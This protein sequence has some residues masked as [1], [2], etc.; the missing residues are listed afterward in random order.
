[1]LARSRFMLVLVVGAL[2]AVLSFSL[3]YLH[4]IPTNP[5]AEQKLLGKSRKRVN[6]VL[7]TDPPAPDPIRDT[8]R[9]C[10][11]PNLTEHGWEGHSPAD[12]RLLS[13]HVMIR[14]GDR[15]PLYSI[16]K[17]KKPAIDCVL[18]DKRKPSHPLLASFI[19]HMALGGRGHWDHLK[20]GDHLRQAYIK[21]HSLLTADWS[22]R[23]L[24]VET[25][26]KSRTLQSGLAFLFGFLP[27]FDWSRLTVRQQWSTLFCGSL[28][29][30]PAR[31]RYLDQEQRRQYR[32]RTADTELER[33][34]ITMAK[35]LG[36]ATK[37]LRAANPVDA[38]LC[39]FCHGLAFPCSSSRTTSKAPDEGAC[40]TLQHFA[41]IRRQQ[42]DDE[43]ERREAGLYRR[44]A[45]LAAHPYLNRTATQMERIA[46]GS[47]ARKGTEEVVFALASAHD[48]TMA[49]L[50][51]ALGLEGAGF[52]KFAARLVFEL[53]NG[54]EAKD[55]ERK[56]DRK[57][58]RWLK[59]MF[60]RVL[61]NGEDL[62]FDTA[63]CRD[64]NR[65]SAQPLCP[66]GNFL[67]FVRNDMFNIVN[68]TS[69]QQA[70]HQTVL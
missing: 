46:R 51:S 36:V 32:Q 56:S 28:C 8:H 30:C 65:H 2:L 70:C 17:T 16:P 21:R 57:R 47:Q 39:H 7:H 59:N 6:P 31:N 61:Y 14:H 66:L 25:T 40:L 45:V 1:M 42:K 34:Y 67:S 60:I 49:P 62:T 55:N 22:P 53:W 24:W 54:P 11:Y 12:Y 13:V 10:N 20:N 29:D 38:L 18:S 33:T 3:Q 48:V 19:S 44:Y 50:L 43:L 35:T 27:R 9:Y 23:Q 68:A 41:V 37:I 5:V 64:H 4:L 58:G 69:Y 52:P 63:F 26:G 15:F